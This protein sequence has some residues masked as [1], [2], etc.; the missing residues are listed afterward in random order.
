[1]QK[2]KIGSYRGVD[3]YTK[4]DHH[5]YVKENFK[6]LGDLIEEKIK[7]NL[8]PEKASVLDIGCA[9]GALISYLS[10]RFSGF[11][12][13]GIDV[14]EELINIAIQQVPGAKFY[15]GGVSDLPSLH[16]KSF[17][18]V[19]CIGV[20]GIFDEDEAKDAL[21]RMIDCAKQSGIIYVFHQF[22]EMDIDVMVKHRRVEPGNKW[23]G[24]GAGWNIYSYRTIG[25]WLG[26]RVRELRFID[27]NMPFPLE[28]QE[29]PVRTWTIEMADG[30][31][32]LTNGLKLMV[33]LKYLEI[34]V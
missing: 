8:L 10:E 11:E 20:I 23:D 2:D 22:N 5:A 4:T 21:Y 14:S 1:M 7:A 9:T 6:K 13:E 17:D 33:D 26:D 3:T 29:N 12:F 28:K 16:E 32:R 25:E 24:W 31:L 15:V 34:I 30:S 18:L 27:F 19:L